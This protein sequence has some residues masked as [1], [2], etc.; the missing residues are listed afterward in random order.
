MKLEQTKITS[1]LDNQ[2]KAANR[3]E[4][5]ETFLPMQ[6]PVKRTYHDKRPDSR[7][8]GAGRPRYASITGRQNSA[9]SD[10]VRYIH[11]SLKILWG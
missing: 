2:C 6:D 5:S 1:G 4:L 7:N 9:A 8:A 3:R 11:Y 10:G